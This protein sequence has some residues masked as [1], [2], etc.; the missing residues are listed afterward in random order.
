MKFF[1]NSVI[2]V[3]VF[4]TPGS[5][6]PSERGDTMRKTVTEHDRKNTPQAGITGTCITEY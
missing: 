6:V 5:T 1:M 2:F 3:V 4:P